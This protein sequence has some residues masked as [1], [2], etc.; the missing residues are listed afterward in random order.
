MKRY[1]DC[2]SFRRNIRLIIEDIPDRRRC[3]CSAVAAPTDKRETYGP[4]DTASEE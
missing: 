2:L 1:V 3:K 4:F